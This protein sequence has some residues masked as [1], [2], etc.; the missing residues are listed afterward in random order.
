MQP[1]EAAAASPRSLQSDVTMSSGAFGVTTHVR[2]HQEAGGSQAVAT[3][4][5]TSGASW[6]SVP[7]HRAAERCPGC[8]RRLAAAARQN[9][10]NF[11]RALHAMRFPCAERRTALSALEWLA[12][13]SILLVLQL[14]R[15]SSLPLY[16][17]RSRC[18]SAPLGSSSLRV[19]VYLFLWLD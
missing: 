11:E 3:S 19:R 10:I 5:A 16:C 12:A 6:R 2:R 4:S 15:I 8:W 13:L 18:V 7:R 1:D 9:S 17:C 14:D